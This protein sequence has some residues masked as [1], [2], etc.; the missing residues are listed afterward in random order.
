MAQRNRD[1]APVTDTD[2]SLQV[3]KTMTFDGGTAN[4]PGDYDGTGNPATLF[5]VTGAVLCRVLAKC[6]TLLEGA[7]ATL[8]VGTAA[9][10]GGIIAQTTATNIDA[11][12]IWHDTS[13]DNTIEASSVLTE[14]IVTDDI[15]QTVGTAN[16]TAGVIE[17]TC[18]WYPLTPDSS[19]VAA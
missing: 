16:I 10:T 5:T 1:S 19:V 9:T 14:N 3:S 15:I 8:E 4:D 6:T 2:W 17:Y 18:I 11:K 7:T 13:P 12:E